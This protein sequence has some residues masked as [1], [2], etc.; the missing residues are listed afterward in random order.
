[1]DLTPEQIRATGVWPRVARSAETSQLAR[2]PMHATQPSCGEELYP[3]ERREVRGSGDRRRPV[4]PL[5]DCH[6]E[7][8]RRE[9]GDIRGGRHQLQ[10][11]FVE[12]DL[13]HPADDANG[14]GDGALGAHGS[15]RLARHLEVVR[16]GEAVGDQGGLQRHHRGSLSEGFRYLVPDLYAAGSTQRGS[17]FDGLLTKRLTG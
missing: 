11:A 2:L 13:S 14:G 12:A 8:P 7:V 3:G 6:R 10:L 15:L 1:M 17:L 16:A 9:L 5:R 4:T